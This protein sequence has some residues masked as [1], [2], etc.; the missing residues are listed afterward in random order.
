MWNEVSSSNADSNMLSGFTQEK[1]H[2]VGNQLNAVF[3]AGRL[4]Q[5]V[6]E[7]ILLS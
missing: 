2:T 6:L 1:T 3:T 4:Q 7:L 5:G